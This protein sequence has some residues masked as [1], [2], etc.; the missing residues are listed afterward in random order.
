MIHPSHSRKEL[1]EIIEIFQIYQVENYR[2]LKKNKLGWTLWGVLTDTKYIRPDQEHYFISD[3]SELREFLRKPSNRQIPNNAVRE[4]VISRVKQLLYYAKT[5]FSFIGS[6]YKTI[7]EV[8]ADAEFV[9]NY[10]DLP[11]VRRALRL[12]NGDGGN[13]GDPK[14]TY[15][16]EAKLTQ[17][18]RER[19][20][21]E[22]KLK[23]DTTLKFRTNTAPV[24]LCFD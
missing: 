4:D 14:M 10:G 18:G 15:T 8:V 19:L 22:K 7:E 12:L 24:V 17:R 5:G 16:I 2:D 9:S 6:N 23:S 1:I 3:V 21:R 20:K 11:A 13:H